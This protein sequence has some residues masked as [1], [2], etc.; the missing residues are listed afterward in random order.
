VNAVIRSLAVHG[1][2]GN[3]KVYHLTMNLFITNGGQKVY[4]PSG[5]HCSSCGFFSGVTLSEESSL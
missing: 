5:I 4:R 3:G 1:E 2:N